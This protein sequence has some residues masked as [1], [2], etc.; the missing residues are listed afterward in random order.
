[1]LCQKCGVREACVVMTSCDGGECYELHVCRECSEG[2]GGFPT[3]EEQR[4]VVAPAMAGAYE[5][6]MDDEAVA[7]ALGLDAEE[8]RRVMRGEGVSSP[9]VWEVI[10]SHLRSE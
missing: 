4:A 2:R 6:G 7:E 10:R 8:L 5:A 9:E 1:M 3:P